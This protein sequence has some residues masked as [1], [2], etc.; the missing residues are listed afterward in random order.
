MMH[1]KKTQEKV[2]SRIEG[3]A[4]VRDSPPKTH[5]PLPIISDAAM[6][7]EFQRGAT[8]KDMM[9]T[10]G[11]SLHTI[12]KKRQKMGLFRAPQ[13]KKGEPYAGNEG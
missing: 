7:A 11:V 1:T 13:R 8:D 5:G 9:E 2:R 6:L 4:I 10:F 12:K 3:V